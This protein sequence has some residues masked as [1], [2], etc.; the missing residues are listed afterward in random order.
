MAQ[1]VTITNPLTGQPAQVDQLEHTAQEIDGAITRALPGGAIDIALQNKEPS[2][3]VLPLSKGGTG[4][5]NLNSLRE[6]IGISKVVSCGAGGSVDIVLPGKGTYLIF[7]NDNA[8]Q[9]A[10]LVQTGNTNGYVNAITTLASLSAWSYAK[11]NGIFTLSETGGKYSTNF[12][13]VS[14]GTSVY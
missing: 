10:I 8:R 7:A 6:L 14:F 9:G 13:V 3:S 12:Y 4:V 2:F 11:G 5:Q 1:I